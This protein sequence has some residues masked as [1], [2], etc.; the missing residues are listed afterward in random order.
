VTPSARANAASWRSSTLGVVILAHRST[1]DVMSC[2]DALEKADDLDLDIVVVD[3]G[4]DDAS[5]HEL[6]DGVGRRGQTLASGDNLGYAAGNN[7]GIQTLLER[8]RELIW[9]LNPDVEVSRDASVHLRRHLAD[10]DDCGVVGPRLV[11][12]EPSIRIQ[13]DGGMVDRTSGGITHLNSGVDPS[14][15]TVSA[16]QD[17]DYVVGASLLFRAEL[18]EQVGLLP[19][20][21]FL[22]FE[23]TEWC[24][25]VR[26][27]GWRVMVEPRALV[28]H[29]RRS[30]GHVPT[31]PYVYYLTRN[32]V[33][34]AE[35][36]LGVDGEEA[37]KVH[38]TEFVDPWR[39]RL[40]RHR[41]EWLPVFDELTRW[42]VDDARQGIRG[43]RDDVHRLVHAEP[44]G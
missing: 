9:L 16:A 3:N 43:R 1:A 44:E 15:V 6:V 22:Y 34:F 8:D 21:Y 2:L 37:L 13:S 4:P 30:F 10:V 12:S 19:E 14:L 20:D 38:T 35:R 27:S 26:E 23:E 40:E 24:L 25:N 42:A 18:V 33:A 17:V 39:R 41:P 32:R 29:H 5:H 36:V 11:E 28:T 31:M 7:L